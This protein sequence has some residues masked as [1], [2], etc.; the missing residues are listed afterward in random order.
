MISQGYSWRVFTKSMCACKSVSLRP[1]ENASDRAA[2]QQ[3][4]LLGEKHPRDLTERW[5]CLTLQVQNCRSEKGNAESKAEEDA[6]VGQRVMGV[7]FEQSQD[8]LVDKH[9]GSSL[10]GAGVKDVEDVKAT[11]LQCK[12]W[13]QLPVAVCQVHWCF[14]KPLSPSSLD[15][16]TNKVSSWVNRWSDDSSNNNTTISRVSMISGYRDSV[17]M[18]PES[19]YLWVSPLRK[20]ITGKGINDASTPSVRVVSYLYKRV[21]DMT[22]ETFQERD[23]F[24]S[25]PEQRP[26]L[27]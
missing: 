20:P 23:L 19:L 4:E 6:P 25:E 14:L 7:P 18:P 10:N 3:A 24:G 1:L 8:P 15:C 2:D 21:A 13:Q 16:L 9:F 26:G 17:E 27:E 12:A 5:V 11:V 22:K